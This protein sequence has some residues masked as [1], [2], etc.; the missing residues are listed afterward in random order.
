MIGTAVRSVAVPDDGD[1]DISGACWPA[2]DSPSG[3]VAQSE[4]QP[5]RNFGTI[6]TG[7]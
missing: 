2:F 6:W 1:P 7:S 4:R 5:W 3:V